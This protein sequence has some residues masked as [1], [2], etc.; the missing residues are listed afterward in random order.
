M[1]AKWIVPWREAQKDDP[2]SF[3]EPFD[4]RHKALLAV[5]VFKRVSHQYDVEMA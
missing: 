4:E 3:N 2:T 5:Y 1:P